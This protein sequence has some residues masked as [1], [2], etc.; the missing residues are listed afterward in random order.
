MA[1]GTKRFGAPPPEDPGD[2]FDQPTRAVPAG[3]MP[4]VST[5]A[6]T[7]DNT[8]VRRSNPMR[9]PV[10]AQTVMMQAA[11]PQGGRAGS[12]GPAAQP[13]EIG[14]TEHQLDHGAPLDARLVL[15]G[16][17]DSERAA[18]F[19]VLRHHLLEQ[20]RPQVVVVSSPLANKAKTTCAVNL[21]L[22]LSECGRAKVL[23]C[24][25][26]VQSPQLARIFNFMPPWCFAE[27][28]DAHRHQSL[29]PWQVVNIPELFTHV[30]AINP[31]IERRQL[32]D[33]PAF[34]IAMDRLRLAGYDHIIIDAPPVLGSA[35]V[36]LIQD[37]ADGI[38]LCLERKKSTAR[39]LR[40]AVEQITPN[41]VVGSILYNG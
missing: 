36:N 30:A 10:P 13:P 41:K 31:S 4:G 17:P 14:I 38:V 35:D 21:A 22:A 12:V 8:V 27:Q 29:L 33:A 25:A 26:D 20:G 5:Q 6:R 3:Q 34:S 15:V 18:A 40:R 1:R 32:L 28:L 37:A 24:E 23:L 16:D 7:S 19:R 11:K 9:E 2:E 39:D